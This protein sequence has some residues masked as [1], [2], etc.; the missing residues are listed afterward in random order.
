MTEQE[1]KKLEQIQKKLKAL[2][3]QKKDIVSREKQRQQ[4]KYEARLIQ[5]GIVSEKCFGFQN[6]HP[7]YYEIFLKMFLSNKGMDKWVEH[8]KIQIRRKN[9]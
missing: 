9:Q 8:T 3:E 1:A 6:V 7:E 4:K 2:Q 5:I